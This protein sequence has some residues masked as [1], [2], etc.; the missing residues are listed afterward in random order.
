MHKVHRSS[1]LC[2]INKL[3]TVHVSMYSFM[4]STSI[5]KRSF[6][7]L[8]CGSA[9]TPQLSTSASPFGP[10]LTSVQQHCRV[11]VDNVSAEAVIQ[12]YVTTWALS[13]RTFLIIKLTI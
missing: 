1:Y 3:P 8:R 7:P 5:H 2:V 10:Q 9:A 6:P 11:I 13:I 12:Y 4:V